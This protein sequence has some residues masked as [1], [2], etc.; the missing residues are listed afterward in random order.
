MWRLNVLLVI[1]VD[2][3]C[4]TV[5]ILLILI[6]S[7]YQSLPIPK[8]KTCVVVLTTWD[9]GS[10][11]Y[12]VCLKLIDLT[13]RHE[14][15]HQMLIILPTLVYQM[16]SFPHLI[17]YAISCNLTSNRSLVLNLTIVVV[18]GAEI[19]MLQA[20]MVRDRQQNSW[21]WL[22]KRS[23]HRPPKLQL[24]TFAD[25]IMRPYVH[26][27]HTPTLFLLHFQL[28]QAMP[29]CSYAYTQ[30]VFSEGLKAAC[31]RAI[32]RALFRHMLE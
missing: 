24:H 7:A 20:C 14:V 25:S 16:V 9:A 12:G 26:T 18:H 15:S 2:S 10:S 5:W 11:N 32:T 3:N 19:N 22:V 23:E 29:T 30:S 21:C 1:C 31:Q 27:V 4:L 13:R 28:L 17:E 8:I 6:Q